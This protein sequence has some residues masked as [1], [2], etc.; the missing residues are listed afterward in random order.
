M[1]GL[2]VGVEVAAA[3]GWIIGLAALAAVGWG[4]QKLARARALLEQKA[5]EAGT[6]KKQLGEA[7]QEG[8]ATLRRVK[9]QAQTDK[10]FAHEPVVKDLLEVVDNFERA[11]ELFPEG[12]QAEGMHLI[13]QQLVAVLARHGV[14]RVP[15][16]GA[17]FDPE[18][19]EAIGTQPSDAHDEHT[20]IQE[21]CGGYRLHDRLLR[22]AKVVLAVPAETDEVPLQTDEVPLQTNETPVVVDETPVEVDETPVEVDETPVV[23]DDAAP[24]ANGAA[25]E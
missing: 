1:A 15:A 5:G 17:P 8:N 4:Q 16:V 24:D 22:A 13:R 9:D 11:L 6:Y 20:V 7:V 12:P 23:A 3:I 25:E 10:R 19:H 21:W 2:R 14:E 18:V